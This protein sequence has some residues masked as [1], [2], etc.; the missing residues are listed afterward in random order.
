MN[1]GYLRDMG[2]IARH[3]VE[4]LVIRKLE[5]IVAAGTA[6]KYHPY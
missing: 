5:I 6:P 4:A 3:G 2:S 1:P